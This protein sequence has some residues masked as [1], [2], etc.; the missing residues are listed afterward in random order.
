MNLVRLF[1]LFVLCLSFIGVTNGVYGQCSNIRFDVGSV[2]DNGDG[3]YTYK[4][5]VC[6]DNGA[7][8]QYIT[9]GIAV[10]LS[11]S[12][13]NILSHSPSRLYSGSDY[14][15]SRV[16]DDIGGAYLNDAFDKYEGSQ[17][18]ITWEY[19]YT[20]PFGTFDPGRSEVCFMNQN[21]SITITVDQLLED[22]N[23]EVTAQFDE[24]YDESPCISGPSQGMPSNPCSLN[25]QTVAIC[26]LS[27]GSTGNYDFQNNLN[28]GQSSI[29]NLSFVDQF[30]DAYTI[31]NE[32]FATVD[33]PEGEEALI[34]TVTDAGCPDTEATLTFERDGPVLK[35][36]IDTINACGG[37]ITLGDY[38]SLF[39]DDNS[40]TMT[41]AMDDNIGSPDYESSNKL[42]QLHIF[43][44][45]NDSDEL[46]GVFLNSSPDANGYRLFY[47]QVYDNPS[48]SVNGLLYV[49]EGD[50]F[51]VTSPIQLEECTDQA[52]HT[53]T[54]G[55]AVETQIT[56]EEATFAWYENSNLTGSITG[57][58]YS[59]NDGDVLYVEITPT[60][61]CPN[62]TATVNFTLSDITAGTINDIE[63]CDGSGVNLDNLVSTV[64]PS[65]N[66][67]VSWYTD[68]SLSNE[69]TSTSNYSGQGIV[70]AQVVNDA[71]T[72][73]D[74]T[75]FSIIQGDVNTLDVELSFC[76]NE[77]GEISLDLNFYEDTLSMGGFVSEWLNAFDQNISTDF[78]SSSSSSVITAI[79]T[80]VSSGC[81]DEATLII[82]M[83]EGPELN[84][85][86]D[87]ACADEEGIAYFNLRDYESLFSQEAG[88]SFEYY[89]DEN[90]FFNVSNPLLAEISGEDVIYVSASTV[91]GCKSNTTLSLTASPIVSQSTQRV[92]CDNDGDGEEIFDLDAIKSTVTGNNAGYNVSWY[93]DSTDLSSQIF[94]PSNYNSQGDEEVYALVEHSQLGCKA[95]ATVLLNIGNIESRDTSLSVCDQGSG[96]VT[97]NLNSASNAVN[98]STNNNVSYYNDPGHTQLISDPEN[99]ALNAT[100]T[101]YA[102]VLFGDC[103]STAEVYLT[104]NSAPVLY[105][106]VYYNCN[107]GDQMSSFDLNSAELD[108]TGGFDYQSAYFSQDPEGSLQISSLTDYYTS[109]TT[110]YYHASNNGCSSFASLDLFVSGL[111]VS[112]SILSSCDDGSG[113]GIYNLSSVEVQITNGNDYEVNWFED[114]E[115]TQNII[116][117]TSYNTDANFV[118]AQVSYGNC[119]DTFAIAEL[120]IEDVEA[121][122][123]QLAGCG[124]NGQGVFNL[125]DVINDINN[126]PSNQLSF[127]YDNNRVNLISP[128]L[129][130]NY[131]AQDGARV[132][133]LV[134]DASGCSDTSSVLLNVN[135]V[136]QANPIDLFGCDYSNN[137]TGIFDLTQ[138]ANIITGGQN[139]SVSYFLDAE[140]TQPVQGD[141]SSYISSSSA[142]VSL[143]SDGVCQN[144]SGV[145][146]IVVGA[147]QANNITI[148]GCDGDLD[149]IADFN[150][151][152]YEDEISNNQ[153]YQFIWSNSQGEIVSNIENVQ[154]ANTTL[155]VLVI[156][157]ATGC[158]TNA[159]AQLVLNQDVPEINY[160]ANCLDNLTTFIY[161]SNGTFTNANWNIDGVSIGQGSS[162]EYLFANA[163]NYTVGLTGN[164]NNC[165]FE[166]STNVEIYS[167]DVIAMQDI[168]IFEGETVELSTNLSQEEDVSHIWIGDYLDNTDSNYPNAS[169]EIEDNNATYTYQVVAINRDSCRA[170]DEINVE[171]NTQRNSGTSTVFTPNGDGENDVF[172]IS[173]SGICE[174]DLNIYNRWG[175]LMFHA[176][177]PNDAWDGTY[178]GKMQPVDGYAFTAKIV[179]CNKEEETLKGLITLIR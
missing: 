158:S 172:M 46:G 13:V 101:V 125:N 60:N 10:I 53:F 168:E 69:I 32:I 146:L 45:F 23:M 148:E 130:E 22:I 152:N 123:S 164:S 4:I 94:F 97:V 20:N 28:M 77:D 119:V 80:E 176:E 141:I 149:N 75:N 44:P 52:T 161:T 6:F 102:K 165:L 54:I 50:E 155:N 156:E 137:G 36:M 85:V 98:N 59:A 35:N 151:V 29:A 142:I 131:I 74:E 90:Q 108:I 51:A 8:V 61:G 171:I 150:L 34:L 3:T 1:K 17:H 106:G 126:V 67:N 91:D 135:E 62:I 159:T 157:P 134:E 27:T 127:F 174:V 117:P 26:E 145:N 107:Q 179:Y 177:D 87:E 153:S 114:V 37:D 96:Q 111:E 49:G 178:N 64:N 25:N 116:N 122:S 9:N 169:P 65:G 103:E 15:G 86:E 58:T 170:Y 143:V 68:E 63:S 2:T 154:S 66:Y 120:F 140:L 11:P 55:S 47:L 18:I 112:N 73:S 33:I 173:G 21:D 89:L 78:V 5:A 82:N 84:A 110:V 72:C 99:Y 12:D 175:H 144:L 167:F 81:Q 163:Q 76:P 121:R 83:S 115:L 166:T 133:A 92:L 56:N 38:V 24:Y 124:E 162:V 100:D 57:S 19:A 95:W 136:P 160:K 139:N 118:F 105:D 39:T 14:L 109:S 40:L 138:G 42:N 132:Y 113:K 128:N 70:Y 88:L 30:G 7:T 147:P 43:D 41:W 104:I 48:C 31:D 16:G 93:R 79:V 129:Y 71:G